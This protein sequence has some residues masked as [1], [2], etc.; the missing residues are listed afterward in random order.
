MKLAPVS[1]NPLEYFALRMNLVPT[2]LIDTQMAFTAARAI[3]AGAQL[4][5]FDALA[6][7]PKDAAGVARECATH[8]E[9]TRQLLDCLVGL[10]YLRF[11]EG[12]YDN[13]EV[14]RKWI[15]RES[16]VSMRDK[17]VFQMLE[18]SWVSRLE[19]F[20]KTGEAIDI[21]AT[22]TGPEWT[23][24]QDG[25]RAL[26]VGVAR[27]IA[28]KLPVPKGASRMLDIGGS[29]GLY[30]VEMCKLHASL[31][32]TILELPEAIPRSRENLAKLGMGA[33]V[34]HQ[35]GDALRDDLGEDNYD[36]VF[37]SNL[38]HHFSAAENAALARR[39]HRALKPGGLYVIADYVRSERP[40]AGGAI[41]ATGDLYFALTSRS[42]TWSRAEMAAWQEEAGMT[43]RRGIRFT[44]M[45]GFVC[46]PGWKSGRSPAS[47]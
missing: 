3:M 10:E 7:G 25:M 5:V 27:E 9:A 36:L 38:V 31:E 23:T 11:S 4:G 41:G 22:M 43:A 8:P 47:S 2:P 16:P 13:S 26:A 28:R 29:H 20:V 17:L 30:S 33:R 42:G 1:E 39:V 37:I 12:R 14:A 46:Q 40:G 24:Y 34:T 19:T 44:T 15:V 6:T 21:H 32:S 18:W 35:A 45:P